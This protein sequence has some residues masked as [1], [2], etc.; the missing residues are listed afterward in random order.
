MTAPG[1]PLRDTRSAYLIVGVVAALVYLNSLGNLFA[2]DDVH[3]VETHEAIQSLETLPGALTTPYWPT[4]YGRELG[5]WRPVTTAL[6]GVQYVVSGGSPVFF[7]AV[8]IVA[9]VGATLLALMLFLELLSLPAAF[10]G[11]LVFAVHPVHVEAVAN[12]VGFSEIIST[13]AL[14]A[15]CLVHLRSGDRSGWKEALLVGLL[16]ALGF[17]AKE[18]GVTLP[19]LIF[20]LDAA[21]GHLGFR[22]LPDYLRRRWP[23]YASMVV[24]AVLLL[25]GRFSVLGSVAHPFA[26]LGADM[27]NEIPRIWTLGEIWLHYVRLWVF[28]LDLSSDYSPNVIRIWTSWGVENTLGVG[29][30]LLFLV[31]SLLSW[32][33]PGLAKGRDTGRLAAFGALWFLISISPTS[34]TVFLSGVLLAERTLYLPSVGLAAASGWLIV[35]M[36]RDRKRVAWAGLAVF[37]LVGSV[38]TWTRNPTWHD[39]GTVFTT[40]MRDYPQAGR[41]QWALA[42]QFMRAGQHQQGLVSYRASI[43]LLNTSYQLVTEIARALINYGYYRGAEGLLGLAIADFPEFTTAYRLMTASRA[44][45]GD[46]EGT[47]AWARRALEAQEGRQTDVARHHLLAWALAAQGE[48]R[49]AE[50]QRAIGDE[51]ARPVFWQGFMYDAYVRWEAG[52]TAAAYASI[53]T[54]WA[55]VMTETGRE[56]IDS[57]RVSEFGLET[58]RL[59]VEPAEPTVP[60]R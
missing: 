18:S 28:P 54:A 11:A 6:F 32:Q 9:H 53:D 13:C 57:V 19:G 55:A 42:D 60:E 40:L 8:N 43:S 1:S 5:L 51:I 23:V 10:A 30:M 49:E 56:A 7:H 26:P 44:E 45:Q 37:V 33:R 46:A 3:I 36:A 38:R 29:M 27:L 22:E 20:L 47:E 21:R 34:N 41:A 17:G 58:L 35:R 25:A 48:F 24:V 59:T 52:D 14:L 15:A 31:L 12:V 39:T 50:E 2:Y 4:A 16:Y